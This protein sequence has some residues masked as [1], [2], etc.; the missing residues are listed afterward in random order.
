MAQWCA[1]QGYEFDRYLQAH[2][3]LVDLPLQVAC[4]WSDDEK[5]FAVFYCA[6]DGQIL[7]EFV[8]GFGEQDSLA[9]ASGKDA[10]LLPR[11]P[12]SWAQAFPGRTIEEV[13]ARH[14]E[15]CRLLERCGAGARTAV[16]P[17]SLRALGEA[18]VRQAR[19]VTGLPLWRWRGVW[20]YFVR[21]NLL[22]DRPIDLRREAD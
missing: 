22:A 3:L 9:T 13:H 14:V 16:K 20:W 2:T 6:P 17:D 18:M 19:Y 8:T 12:G 1:Q 21:R 5:T 11:P 7:F 10:M 15:A 4:W